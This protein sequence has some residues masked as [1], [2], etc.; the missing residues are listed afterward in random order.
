MLWIENIVERKSTSSFF[1]NS[2]FDTVG[3][4]NLHKAVA[5]S[6]F[7]IFPSARNEGEN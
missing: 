6:P 2:I 5:R 7:L 4:V 1:I 3:I